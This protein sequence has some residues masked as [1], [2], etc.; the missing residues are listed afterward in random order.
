MVPMLSLELVGPDDWVEWRHVRLQALA[1]APDAFSSSRSE[2]EHADE[3]RWRAR[4]SD[5]PYN[6]LARRQLVVAGMVSAMPPTDGEASLVSMWVAPQA[7]GQGV[8][9][10]LVA[11]VL[12]WAADLGA[13]RVGLDVRVAN[14]HAKGLY[15]RH[16]FRVVGSARPARDGVPEVRMHRLLDS[17]R[18]F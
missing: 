10:A 4:L 11:R 16:G 6:V 14:D 5:V 18:I 9:D 2:W 17:H 1:E 3:A 12:G 15:A 13:M 7:R 8:G